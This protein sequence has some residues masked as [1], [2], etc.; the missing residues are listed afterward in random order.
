MLSTIPLHI[1][2][3]PPVQNKTF[4]SKILSLKVEDEG[5]WSATYGVLLGVGTIVVG[6]RPVRELFRAGRQFYLSQAP[7]VLYIPPPLMKVKVNHWHAVAHW[8]WDIGAD[9]TEAEDDEEEDVCG[10]C[11]V[12]FEGCCPTCKTPGD[13]CPLSECSVD[14]HDGGIFNRGF[15]S[16]GP[17]HPC[18]PY[19]LLNQVARSTGIKT[20]MSDGPAPLG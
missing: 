15:C 7:G 17:V 11:R 10:I 2:L 16:L 8:K 6:N 9:T 20:A 19:A 13:D 1:P 12:A 4:P 18:L 3:P 5:I 14:S